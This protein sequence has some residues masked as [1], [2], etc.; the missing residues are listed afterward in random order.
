M[1]KETDRDA[2][3]GLMKQH[4]LTLITSD[5]TPEEVA[6]HKETKRAE[7]EVL[8]AL[9]IEGIYSNE[10][11]VISDI[12][13]KIEQRKYINKKSRHFELLCELLGI[14]NMM[15]RLFAEID[16]EAT[17]EHYLSA[18]VSHSMDQYEA[19]IKKWANCDNP[20]LPEFNDIDN[21][22]FCDDDMLTIEERAEYLILYG[23]GNIWWNYDKESHND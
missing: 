9:D 13:G 20:E 6:E 12:L 4:G 17:N 16:G 11:N 10:M 15:G 18:I 1:D 3:W 22:V 5:S 14:H 8:E 21:D 7:A 19:I 23:Q 2:A